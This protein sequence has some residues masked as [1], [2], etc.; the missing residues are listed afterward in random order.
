MGWLIIPFIII[1]IIL[2][3]GFAR[4]S[5]QSYRNGEGMFKSSKYNLDEKDELSD[6]KY[7]HEE[8]LFK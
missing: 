4:G 5:H 6:K 1:I 7:Y 3:I 2:G 8:G